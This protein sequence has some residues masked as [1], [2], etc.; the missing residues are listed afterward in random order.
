MMLD[1]LGYCL[2]ASCQ[3]VSFIGKSKKAAVTA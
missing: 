1:Y 2:L 3:K